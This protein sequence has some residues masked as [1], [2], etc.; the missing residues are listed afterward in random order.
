[1]NNYS[2]VW[3]VLTCFLTISLFV[4][5]PSDGLA[6]ETKKKSNGR[7]SYQ[8][9]S[10]YETQ[11]NNDVGQDEDSGPES[12]LVSLFK[13][14]FSH[15]FRSL[16]FLDIQYPADSTQNPRNAFLDLYRYS[17]EV[18]LRPDFHLRLPYL[19]A[20][21]KPRLYSSYRQYKDGFNSGYED[22]HTYLDTLE[23]WAQGRIYDSLFVSYG[24]QRL[25]WGASFLSNPSNPFFKDNGKKN[26]LREIEGKYF[27]KMVYLPNDYATLTWMSKTKK[28]ESEIKADFKPTHALKI[29]ILK[30]D[31]FLGVI[32][33]KRE[34]ER[35]QFGGF[36]Q[37]TVSDSTILYYDGMLSKGNEVLY[38]GT[39]NDSPLGM[40]FSRRFKESSK[41]FP[42]VLVGGAYTLL[43]GETL[44][45][46]FLYN[47]AG[48]N[49]RQAQ[50]YFE[51]R[52]TAADHF[53]DDST[54]SGLSAKT[55]LD[56]KDNG[57]L[58]LRRKYLMLQ[59]MK[60]EIQDVLDVSVRYIHNLDDNS[61]LINSIVEWGVSDNI[62]LFNVLLIS[63]G[64][65]ESEF[66][67]VLD[68][69]VMIGMEHTF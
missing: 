16:F 29:E 58:H 52:K 51:L 57:L 39:D 46:E 53:F 10:P 43:S 17:Y 56:A 4:L 13:D 61:G 68:T 33:S 2:S 54:L 12:P 1:M 62:R 22:D 20:V 7:D 30:S 38:P 40:S 14:R 31:Y 9:L 65:D 45:L 26:T 41:I 32:V 6:D 63:V 19:K 50:E 8:G 66:K 69:S 42:V 59:Y 37:Y 44:S 18:N 11:F 55:L 21:Y 67:A 3:L 49:D 15:M 25:L 27:L 60:K 5:F 24:K 28:D 47:A 23:F 48:Y 35:F 36:A 64:D 34:D